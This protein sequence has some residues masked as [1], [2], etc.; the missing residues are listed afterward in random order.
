MTS[1]LSIPTIH[2]GDEIKKKF[3]ESGLTQREFGARI[4]MSQQNVHRVFDNESLDTKRLVAVSLAL[5]F[6]FFELF[7]NPS[8]TSVHTEGDQSP[9]SHSGTIS[10]VY[11]DAVLAEKVKSLEAQLK[12]KEKII[13]LLEGMK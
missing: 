12:D 1:K 10:M 4:G 6:N 3:D 13:A 11:G 2:L 5:N 9:A 7:S 8:V